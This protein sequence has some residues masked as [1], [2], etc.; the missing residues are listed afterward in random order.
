MRQFKK[1]AF[2]ILTAA[3]MSV[4]ALSLT[5]CGNG[6]QPVAADNS[7]NVQSN[8]GFAVSTN[9][10]YY[11][12]NGVEEYSAE[13]TYGDVVKGALMRVK[14]DE[15][16]QNKYETVIPSLLAAGDYE[17]GV[18]IYG[19]RIY[20]ATPNNVKNTSGVVENDYLDFKSAKTDGS[21]VRDIF[22]A[23]KNAVQY[24]FVE[25]GE[26]AEKSVYL[27][28]VNEKDLHSYNVSTNTDTVL[29]K[30]G[31]YVFN[32]T[33]KSDPYVYYTMSVTDKMDSDFSVSYKYNQIYRVRAD[34]TKA[35]YDY[36]WDQK[37]LDENNN[38]EVPYVNFGEL[39]LD[40]IGITDLG[41]QDDAGQK[42]V[43]TQFNKD[44]AEDL[45]NCPA[46]GYIYTL[47]S[48]TNQ[49]IYFKRTLVYTPGS[50][51]GSE[52]ELY[53]LPASDV[54]AEWNT[55]EGNNGLDVVAN[56]TNLSKASA[57]ALFYL[58]GEEHHYVYVT[59]T[60]IYRVDVNKQDGSNSKEVQ[61]AYDA[62]GATLIS[63]DA[64]SDET[65]HYVYYSRSNNGGLS[66]E[67]AV[68]N[69]DEKD[70]SNLIFGDKDNKPYEPVK[71]L[72]VQHA[73]GWY[74]YE[75]IDN[76]LFYAN[77]ESFGTSLN[78]IYAADLKNADGSLM[79]N[80]ELD[81]LNQKYNSIFATDKKEGYLQKVNQEIGSDY[82]N[83]L[84]YYFYTNETALFWENIQEARDAGKSE[85]YITKNLYSLEQQKLFAAF[86]GGEDKFEGLEKSED[87]QKFYDENE[88]FYF[89]L[90]YFTNMLGGMKEADEDAYEQYWKS[91]VL[92]VFVPEAEEK[93]ELAWW[94]WMLIALALAAAV[95]GVAVFV[96]R[97]KKRHA[98]GEPKP[99]KMRVD[100][101]DDKDVDVYGVND[102]NTA[103]S[104]EET[105]SEEET[106]EPEAE[107]V[108]EETAEEAEPAA[109]PTEVQ[110][111]NAED[112]EPEGAEDAPAEEKDPYEN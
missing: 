60:N 31:T 17:S 56:S 53:Y 38:G 45:S 14:K 65:Y 34:A 29:V 22:R 74:E 86:T 54:T 57:A 11:F 66:V 102:A 18:Y 75:M 21:D 97:Y 43:A 77:S 105:V 44:A 55:V 73:S 82:S 37:W 33:D 26:G 19:D 27:L 49:G 96:L 87:L 85:S 2:C 63:L 92:K 62:S 25:V 6:F 15:V 103:E 111:E 3:V 106:Q 90:N 9:D 13:N 47:Q 67:R 12:I 35:P 99:E 88:T 70:Y 95:A 48:Y 89:N 109:E 16:K 23:E 72:N 20:Y 52:G 8:G 4:G 104:G 84:K 64:V 28:Y 7:G 83:A 32:D 40:G 107:P 76:I 100:T 5:A 93:E 80:E 91:S 30:G 79:N 81:A 69:G 59:G 58:D 50:T 101:T 39:V 68:Y 1:K 10:Y 110:T 108:Q 51:V 61:I 42:V 36:T 94:A 71:L 98:D 112:N 46:I 78:Y 24:R 41:M